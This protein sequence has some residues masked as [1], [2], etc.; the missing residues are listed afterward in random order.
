[1]RGRYRGERRRHHR[2]PRRRQEGA[3]QAG[4]GASPRMSVR[5]VI[6]QGEHIARLAA[7]FGFGDPAAIWDHPDNAALKKKPGHP[8]ALAPGD[9]VAIPDREPA[10]F[11]VATGQGHKFVI[12]QPRVTVRFKLLD[13]FGKPVANT[14]CELAVE[15]ASEKLQTDGDGLVEKE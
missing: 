7:E 14:E 1:A 3:Q 6:R 2:L 12:K 5:H 11:S 13:L 15:G 9:V 10:Q 8:T 4:G